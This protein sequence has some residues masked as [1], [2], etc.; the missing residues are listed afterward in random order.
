[1]NEPAC[2][3]SPRSVVTLR[4]ID[5]DSVRSICDLSVRD[6]QTRARR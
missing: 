4:E 2:T 6:D 5:E 1:M 3:L